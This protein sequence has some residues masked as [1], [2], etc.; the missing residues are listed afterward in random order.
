M[1]AAKKDCNS[2]PRIRPPRAGKPAPK[3]GPPDPDEG[4]AEEP[5]PS[6][7]SGCQSGLARLAARLRKPSA[8]TPL[9]DLPA[10]PPDVV[11]KVLDR[12]DAAL[13]ERQLD[14][15]CELYGAILMALMPADF[16]VPDLPDE[17]TD[18]PPGPGGYPPS[19]ALGSEKGIKSARVRVYIRRCRAAVH[20]YHPDD[21]PGDQERKG[22]KPSWVGQ[23]DPT[24]AGWQAEPP[25]AGPDPDAAD[26]G[27][28]I[29]DV[30]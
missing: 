10:I 8:V 7:Q 21:A 11:P 4:P 29:E 14:V 2:P 13:Y 17:P 27:H 6:R 20:L 16:E 5:P 1:A 15:D 28:S 30:Y 3:T 25:P 24:V 9:D 22:L 23:T 12:L 26:V 19:R 18:T